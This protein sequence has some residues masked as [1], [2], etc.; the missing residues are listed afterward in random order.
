MPGSVIGKQMNNGYPGTVSRLADAIIANRSVRPTDANNINF[1]DPVVLNTDNTYS[2]FC[3]GVTSLTTALVS[4]T[5]YTT[6]AVAALTAPVYIGDSVLV[7]SGATTQVVTAR[8]GAVIGATSIDVDS[9]AANA[10]YAVG[11][12]VVAFNNFM[13]FAGV[14][15]REVKQSTSY[16]TSQGDY[17]PGQPCD[18]LERG[19][20]TVNCNHGTPT[21]RGQ[22]YVRV[23]FNNAY[24]NAPV[25]G[26]EAV[27]DGT[28]TIQITNA[29]WK[30]GNLDS[31]GVA[32]LTILT[33]NNA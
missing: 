3:A 24:P 29:Q 10:A 19:S 20:V 30:T 13:Q 27:S 5:S 14:A 12:S 18:V 28:N 15:V 17:E 4:G 32:E 25:G 2:K 21:A 11:V 31:N 7:G 6:L 22:V 26:F 1:G 33:R 16:F 9:F 8:T 23:I